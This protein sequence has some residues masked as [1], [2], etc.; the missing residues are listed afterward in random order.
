MK[1]LKMIIFLAAF[2][3][4]SAH[5]GEVDSRNDIF[6]DLERDEWLERH[7]PCH[8]DGYYDHHL[9]TPQQHRNCRV[10]PCGYGSMQMPTSKA[11]M[12]KYA[13]R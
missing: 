4:S 6:R 11:K 7:V 12:R 2:A 1:K 8:H 13:G 10:L 3:V 9:Y 5:A